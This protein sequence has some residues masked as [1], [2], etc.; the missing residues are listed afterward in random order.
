LICGSESACDGADDCDP[1]WCPEGSSCVSV[2]NTEHMACE[3]NPN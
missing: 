2:D 3:P 1:E